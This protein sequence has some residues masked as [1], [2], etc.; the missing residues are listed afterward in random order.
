[1][2]AA[3]PFV[4]AATLLASSDLT[5]HGVGLNPTRTGLLDVLARMGARVTVFHRRRLGE[6][7]VADLQAHHASLV[8]AEVT[9]HQVP[10]LVD[11]L[12]LFAL[13]AASARGESVVRG[14]GEL[15]VKESDRIETVTAALRALGARVA[16]TPDGFQIRGVPARLRG[17]KVRSEGDHRIAILGA[18]AGVAS[19][20]GVRL[21]GAEA[22]AV[23]FPGFFE[24]LDRVARRA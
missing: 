19:R 3:A 11:E 18:V 17:G 12:P 7:P 21:E 9:P 15:R 22:V 2:S 16:A 1:L 20:E 24:L 6:E 23:S 4:V 10:L 5:V 14:A 8:A 13:A